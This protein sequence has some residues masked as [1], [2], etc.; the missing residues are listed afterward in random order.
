MKLKFNHVD[1]LYGDKAP[2]LFEAL[3]DIDCEIKEHS[4]TCI[5]GH[6]GCGKSTFI[7]QLNGLLIPTKG[8]VFAGDFVIS[9]NKKERT[10]KL[11]PLRQKVG[12]VF[13][14]SEYQLFENT[15]EEDVAFGPTNFGVSKED[16]LKL[17]HE[18]LLKVGLDE[19]FF[20]KSPFELSGGE[21]RRV[22]IAGIMAMQPEVIV[23]DEP[24]VGLDPRGV[25]EMMSLFKNLHDQ[26]TTL[27]VVTHDMN[28]VYGYATDVIVMDQGKIVYQGNP[29]DLFDQNVDCYSLETPLITKLIQSLENKGYKFDLEKIS[30]LDDVVKEIAK[31]RRASKWAV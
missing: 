24:T 4:F 21:R 11:R 26:G 10:K 30:S 16:A 19:S 9:S 7:Q 23:L 28:L 20:K 22:A 5:V 12:I 25:K 8:S 18:N 14:F 6:T 2:N 3:H 1:F 13:Q 17:A 15:V 29:H 31:Q 27:I